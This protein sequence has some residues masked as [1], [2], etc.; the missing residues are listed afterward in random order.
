MGHELDLTMKIALDV[1]TTALIGYAHTWP[2]GFISTTDDD[3]EPDLIYA[4]IKYKF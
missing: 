1:H 3:D 4:Q 2:S